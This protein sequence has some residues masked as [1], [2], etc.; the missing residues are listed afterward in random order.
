MIKILGGLAAAAA[1]ATMHLDLTYMGRGAAYFGGGNFIVT[2]VRTR[3]LVDGERLFPPLS[4]AGYPP[5][6]LL[7]N[8][9]PVLNKDHHFA[10]WLTNNAPAIADRFSGIL[11]MLRVTL[12]SD[13][14]LAF[15]RQRENWR[16][17][18]VEDVNGALER[19][20]E[21]EPALKPARNAMLREEDVQFES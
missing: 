17:A 4:F 21:L 15:G 8:Q 20:F 13:A 14:S 16:K 5:T 7:R 3:P 2:N 9:Y 1:L 6:G 18:I 12:L 11:E 19:L 10:I